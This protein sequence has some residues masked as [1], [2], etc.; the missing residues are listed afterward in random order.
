MEGN[1][2]KKKFFLLLLG[3]NG[4]IYA[5]EFPVLKGDYL[6]QTPPGDTP[7]VF[8]PGVISKS[9]LEHSAPAFSPDGREIYWS[10]IR[11]SH[12]T[13]FQDIMVVKRI[14]NDWSKPQTASFSGKYYNGG[15]VF[16]I[17][18]KK[19]FIYR[20]EPIPSGKEVTQFI[21]CFSNSNGDWVNPQMIV[22]GFSPSITKTGTIYYDDAK[23]I[24]RV[25]FE[26]GKY[27]EPELLNSQ[28][29]MQGYK[30]WTPFI[31]PDESYLIFS[32]VDFQGDYGN[33]FITFHDNE[34]DK[35]SNPVDMGSP[36]NTW[37]QERFPSVSP[38]GKYL[39]C[40]RW[41]KENDQD[42]FWVSAKIIDRLRTNALKNK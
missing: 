10:M 30:N 20:S 14:D 21:F 1:S 27:T 29:N 11:K 13:I 40:T 9:S 34:S 19:L 35:W 4:F 23:G 39:F 17:N 3:F 6:G 38:D 32:R 5:Q 24:S 36:V 7:V 2:M 18:G 22:K 12:D 41:T 26:S 33:L 37:A 16:S 42:I 8:A 31:A 25:R 28:I 15:P